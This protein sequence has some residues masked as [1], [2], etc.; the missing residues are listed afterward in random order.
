M[1]TR[2][3]RERFLHPHDVGVVARFELGDARVRVA[4]V[5]ARPLDV[6]RRIRDIAEA[7][8]AVLD[9]RDESAHAKAEQIGLHLLTDLVLALRERRREEDLPLVIEALE[10]VEAA[11]GWTIAVGP[12]VV[13]RREDRRRL[14]RVEVGLRAR[15]ERVVAR[16]VR[17][18]LEVAVERR[19]REPLAVHVR[20]QVGDTDRGLNR[21]VR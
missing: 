8:A 21:R 17:T 5:V 12:V 16:R 19:K 15:V 1:A 6:E 18:S 20:N 14:Q 9:A 11:V 4:E 7:P 13:A 10:R 2:G 3:L